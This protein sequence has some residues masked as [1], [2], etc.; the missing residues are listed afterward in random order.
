MQWDIPADGA[1][2]SALVKLK[3]WVGAPCAGQD[4][5]SRE[6]LAWFL[7]VLELGPQVMSSS[8]LSVE[9]ALL[10]VEACLTTVQDQDPAD[11]Y[12]AWRAFVAA[13]MVGQALP[14][15]EADRASAKGSLHMAAFALSRLVG[16]GFIKYAPV[17]PV[18]DG[19]FAV[20]QPLTRA[21]FIHKTVDG[22][23]FVDRADAMAL[24]SKLGMENPSTIDGPWQQLADRIADRLSSSATTAL[25]DARSSADAWR[26]AVAKISP[27]GGLMPTPQQRQHQEQQ[28]QRL[29]GSV[30]KVALEE[31][32]RR[33]FAGCS[34][35]AVCAHV[36]DEIFDN[37][38]PERGVKRK[39]DAA[40]AGY[41][42]MRAVVKSVQEMAAEAGVVA[43]HELTPPPVA[44]DVGDA[45]RPVKERQSA[46]EFYFDPADRAEEAILARTTAGAQVQMR[47]VAAAAQPPPSAGPV[48]TAL[49]TAPPAAQHFTILPAA[50]TDEDDPSSQVPPLILQAA[51]SD[52][53]R[54]SR[55]V[56]SEG[57]QQRDVVE[58]VAACNEHSWR[59][60]SRTIAAGHADESKQGKIRIVRK[61][62]V[63]ATCAFVKNDSKAN[64][65]CSGL[66]LDEK[67]VRG[68]LKGELFAESPHK[69]SLNPQYPTFVSFLESLFTWNSDEFYTTLERYF[70]AVDLA[71]A[72]GGLDCFEEL[73]ALWKTREDGGSVY[74]HTKVHRGLGLA[75][76]LHR[77]ATLYKDWLDPASQGA[78]R[79]K[80]SE[81]R[82]WPGSDWV[83]GSGNGVSNSRLEGWVS[84]TCEVP[85]VLR[86][87]RDRLVLAYAKAASKDSSAP[88]KAAGGGGGGSGS[89]GD[90]GGSKDFKALAR[91]LEK[92]QSGISDLKKRSS[93]G[94][95]GDGRQGKQVKA[96]PDD[97]GGHGD[98]PASTPKQVRVG[99]GAGPTGGGQPKPAN[100]DGEQSSL[101][102]MQR[103]KLSLAYALS[104]NDDK[105]KPVKEVLDKTDGELGRQGQHR[106]CRSWL[107][108]AKCKHP[109]TD[110]RCQFGAHY[111]TKESAKFCIS[112]VNDLS[113]AEGRGQL[114][115]KDFPKSDYGP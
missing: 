101:G 89:G 90:G 25:R 63:G 69:V 57:C 76:V 75:F 47:A 22:F 96:K 11:H 67:A 66:T 16:P 100:R 108:F 68:W 58:A 114:G 40:G 78:P 48:A 32:Q 73:R 21:V 64:S 61:A 97:D 56:S 106:T 4:R 53:E 5:W 112:L 42:K 41:L 9:K 85:P 31:V 19:A 45:E 60:L 6:E 13:K 59:A 23:F 115:L 84:G 35:E 88:P 1:D 80:L 15:A 7:G 83:F 62:L 87:I 95:D 54:C 107:C 74:G 44:A 29:V 109:V 12:G 93:A 3:T 27:D 81:F 52:M 113:E 36:V 71:L 50:G 10:V 65:A 94:G 55:V 111:V 102:S 77:F 28:Q 14:V 30:G 98:G 8:G 86:T 110:R 37:T 46:C 17:V 49:Q 33:F 82:S 70:T 43:P 18:V 24:A 105:V 51:S 72:V 2:V 99:D 103:S 104:S 38:P 91:S 20:V 39:I 79:P 26:A 92:L 34:N